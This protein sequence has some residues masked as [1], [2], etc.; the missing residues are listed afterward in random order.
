MSLVT[1][2]DFTKVGGTAITLTASGGETPSVSISDIDIYG[3]SNVTIQLLNGVYQSN[4]TIDDGDSTKITVSAYGN[5]GIGYASDVLATMDVGANSNRILS[6]PI[7][8]FLMK[9]T[10]TNTDV[11][12]AST[13]KYMI[14]VRK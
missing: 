10:F 5:T 9:V 14:V 6:V 7:G 2:G 13:I 1:H 11:E 3:A 8:D 12:N 4:G